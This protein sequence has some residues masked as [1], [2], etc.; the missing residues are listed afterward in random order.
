[1]ANGLL[2]HLKEVDKECRAAQQDRS[3][4]DNVFSNEESR[5]R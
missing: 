5:E 3:D 1:M 4:S 2:T